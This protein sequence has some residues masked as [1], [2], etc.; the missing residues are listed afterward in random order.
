[1]SRWGE[2]NRDREVTCITGVFDGD[3]SNPTSSEDFVVVGRKKGTVDVYQSRVG[4]LVTTLPSTSSGDKDG[5][6]IRG[7]NSFWR[8]GTP[9][10]ISA[11]ASGHIRIHAS[12]E[13]EWSEASSFDSKVKGLTGTSLF[14]PAL[15]LALGGDGTDLAVWDL[16]KK[17]KHFQAKPTKPNK[18]GLTDKPGITAITHVP[19]SQG[20]RIVTGTAVHK[21]RLYDIG[22][23][24]RPVAEI[25]WGE[26][27]V[28][29]V[30]PEN[31][32]SVWAANALGLIQLWDLR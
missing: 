8:S 28:T 4:T 29:A 10:V 12:A 17:E 2:G 11:T 22:A 18:L 31:E 21:L 19:G 24:K 25:S 32:H 9:S 30:A 6:V 1:M 20:K 7:L 15:Q 14:R 16:E 27:R 3:L 5:R 23:Q 13:G 26:G